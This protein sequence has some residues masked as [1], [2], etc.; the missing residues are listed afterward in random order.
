MNPVMCLL[1]LLTAL[2]L[3]PATAG[4]LFGV[5]AGMALSL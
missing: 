1:A 3:I 5:A 4:G 2:A